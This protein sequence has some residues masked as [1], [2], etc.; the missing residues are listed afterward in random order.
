MATKA[1]LALTARSVAA[2]KPKLGATV[3]VAFTEP[4]G[5]RL[6]VYPSGR[7]AFAVRY[8][9]EGGER[10]LIMLGDYGALTVDAAR[11]MALDILSRV[12]HGDDPSEERATARAERTFAHW[13]EEYIQRAKGRKKTWKRDV[14]YLALAVELFGKKRL[15]EVAARDCDIF[16]ERT[17]EARGDTSANRALASLKT[18]LG[19]A[20][21]L[22]YIEANPALRV[23]PLREP[24]PRTRVFSEDE[25]RRLLAAVAHLKDPSAK[26]GMALLFSTGCRLS[27]ALGLRWQDV[28]LNAGVLRLPNPKSGKPQSIPL[29]APVG[30]FLKTLPKASAYVVAGRYP[31][32]PRADLKGAWGAVTTE[33]G[34]KGTVHDIR[35]TVGTNIASKYGLETA[36][37][38]LRH[39]SPNVT[40][41]HYVQAKDNDLR[42]A[43]EGLAE[44]SGLDNVLP[45]RPKAGGE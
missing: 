14:Q 23:K 27:E 38:I 24:A 12:V 16:F 18:C 4:Q 8:T 37:H 2:I 20:W 5:L 43:L 29:P 9:S 36:Q 17:R 26:A 41:R 13:K 15:S 30:G 40:W 39:S 44:D 33:S 32:R 21:R 6:I 1:R 3:Q 28:D 25:Q 10:K 11:K 22:G 31:D 19:T 34:V 7:R 45:M 35:R 42:R